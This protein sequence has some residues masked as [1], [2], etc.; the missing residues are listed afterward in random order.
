MNKDELTAIRAR[1]RRGRKDAKAPLPKIKF[2]QSWT[3]GTMAAKREYFGDKKVCGT[4][5]S[6][7]DNQCRMNMGVKARIELGAQYA[8]GVK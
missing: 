8:R 4:W 1:I 7:V 3:T 5:T 2:E 6:L